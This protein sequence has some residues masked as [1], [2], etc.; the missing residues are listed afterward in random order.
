[1]YRFVSD[2]CSLT[3]HS[4][5][6]KKSTHCL[7]AAQLVLVLSSA[8]QMLYSLL[9]VDLSFHWQTLA[10]SNDFVSCCFRFRFETSGQICWSIHHMTTTVSG[11]RGS[12]LPTVHWQLIIKAGS[13][14]L[15]HCAMLSYIKSTTLPCCLPL[16]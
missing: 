11:H 1:M 4:V 16:G 13:Q 12:L 5:L 9:S 10:L 14:Y 3:R 8:L 6:L 2:V 7:Q 15:P